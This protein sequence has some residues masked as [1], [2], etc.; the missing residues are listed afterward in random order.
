MYHLMMLELEG[1]MNYEFF[2]QTA[3][4][5]PFIPIKIKP[6]PLESC[7]RGLTQRRKQGLDEV[8]GLIANSER[9]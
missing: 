9:F 8:F 1:I 6:Y 5:A 4:S 3:D 7:C 2:Y